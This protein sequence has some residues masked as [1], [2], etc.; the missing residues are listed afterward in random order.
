MLTALYDLEKEV[1]K[2]A[3]TIE[4]LRQD[5]EELQQDLQAAKDKIAGLELLLQTYQESHTFLFNSQW[6]R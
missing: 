4:N 6:R 3:E 1:T 2:A 5:K